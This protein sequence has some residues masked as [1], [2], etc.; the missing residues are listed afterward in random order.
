[1]PLLHDMLLASMSR[2]PDKTAL[3]FRDRR[4]TYREL[5]AAAVNLAA[6]LRALGVAR[7]DRVALL[8]E[9][10]LDYAAVVFAVSMAGAVFVPVNSRFGPDEIAYVVNHARPRLLLVGAGLRATADKAGGAFDAG[11]RIV[12][13]PPLDT[14]SQDAGPA[15]LE[16]GETDPEAPAMIMYT[17]GTTGFPK[18]ALLSHA[19]YRANVEAIAAAGELS[20]SDVVMVSLPL[21]HNGGLIAVLMPALHLGA[22]AVIMPRGFAPDSVL[23][24]V[25]RHRVTVTMWVPTMLA[26]LVESG[27]PGRHDVT[28]LTRIWYGSSPIAPDLLARV[29]QGFD[30]GLYQFYGMTETGMTAVLSPADHLVHPQATG[31]AMPPA[32]L[33]LVTATGTEAAAGEIGELYSRREPLGMSGYFD[34]E[35]ATRETVVDGWIRTGDVARNLGDGY[36]VIV[37]RQ[38]DMI[39]SGAENIYPREIEN[40]LCLHPEV[41]E[42]AVFGIPDPTYGEAVCAAVVPRAPSA[43]TEGDLVAWCASRLAGY[44]KPKRVLLLDELPRNA[45]GKVL[46]QALRSSFWQGSE[47]S[48]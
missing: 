26:M 3:I 2:D 18:G 35:E 48:I 32:R 4:L 30:A 42:A 36:F 27:A 28:S 1:M 45:A 22:T 17:S 25:E 16:P 39:I 31:R 8:D 44:K 24:E 46:K 29:R 21:F 20:G 23:A 14:L 41:A 43:V 15:G 34:N 19:A 12:D 13:L 11:T 37:D 47:R 10:S 7:G 5:A 40:A 9:N 6:R 33:R 38:K